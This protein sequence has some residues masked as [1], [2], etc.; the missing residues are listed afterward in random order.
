M[1]GVKKESAKKEEEDDWGGEWDEHDKS[2][3]A[4]GFGFNKKGNNTGKNNDNYLQ[5]EARSSMG[6]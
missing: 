2:A 5:N 1:F 4:S 3:N 6:S